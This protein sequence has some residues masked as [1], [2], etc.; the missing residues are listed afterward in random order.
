MTS[1]HGKQSFSYH[2]WSVSSSPP[3][4]NRHIFEK[5]M[6]VRS[7]DE[8]FVIPNAERVLL[9]QAQDLQGLLEATHD[10]GLRYLHTCWN[11]SC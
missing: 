1:L 6:N 10:V 11:H 2:A 7:P 3:T 4:R 8:S 9:F 5:E